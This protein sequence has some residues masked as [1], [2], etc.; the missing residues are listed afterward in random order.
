MQS[1]RDVTSTGKTAL[2]T[3]AGVRIGRAT[4]LALA[5]AGL[6]VLVHY[7]RSEAEAAEVC[8]LAEQRG[9]RAWPI[10]ADFDEPQASARLID[11]AIATAPSLQVLVNN[12]AGFPQD[13]LRSMTFDGLM[14]TMRTN[15]WAPLALSRAFAERVDQ[16]H[17]VNLLDS[18]IVDVDWK[19]VSYTLSKQVL[20]SLTKMMA[21]DFAPKIAVNAV[22]PGLILPPPG[23]PQEYLEKRTGTVPLKRHGMPEQIAR[24]VVRRR[25]AADP[26]RMF[27]ARREQHDCGSRHRGL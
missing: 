14:A 24:A 17:I 9:V 27:Q 1:S 19:H 26:R 7:R 3:G 12:A 15:A 4:A 13:D 8:R 22:A 2:V 16:G 18:R 10:P 6:N 5:D 23:A 11:R 21:L 25:E 20:A